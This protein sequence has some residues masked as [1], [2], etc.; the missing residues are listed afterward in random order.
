MPSLCL[1]LCER[2]KKIPTKG[3]IRKHNSCYCS[4]CAVAFRLEIISCPCCKL[5]VRRR[6]RNP[7][8]SRNSK[9]D[10]Q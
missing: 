3:W 6:I 2:F 9:R 4:V 1:G 7:H 10:I 8:N 5:K